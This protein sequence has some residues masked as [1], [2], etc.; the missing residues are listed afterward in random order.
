M[1]PGD[2]VIYGV[3]NGNYVDVTTYGLRPVVFKNTLICVDSNYRLEMH[4]GIDE[5]NAAGVENGEFKLSF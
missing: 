4:I 5:A 3:S 2:A 1:T